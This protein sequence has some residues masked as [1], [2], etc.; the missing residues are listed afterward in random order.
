MACCAC[1]VLLIGSV[2]LTLLG[3][4]QRH[5]PTLTQADTG[6][7]QHRFPC[8]L[9]SVRWPGRSPHSPCGA[10]ISD[11]LLWR[12]SLQGRARSHSPHLW[13]RIHRTG[14]G[15][16]G[17][18]NNTARDYSGLSSLSCPSVLQELHFLTSLA[19]SQSLL[20]SVS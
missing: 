14:R 3:S 17:Y 4:A 10:C 11:N 12:T 1:G 9:V 6:H 8:L 16:R 20:L 5:T 7:T 19:L 2:F 13:C 15:G 18:K